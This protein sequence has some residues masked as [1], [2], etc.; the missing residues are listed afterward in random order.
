MPLESAI[1]YAD[2]I[3]T[4]ICDGFV[5]GPFDDPPFP[6]FRANPLFVIKQ[7]NKLR[8]ILDLSS[9]E[10]QSFNDA[11][12][13]SQV[14]D[15]SMALPRDIADLLLEFGNEAFLSKLDHKSAFRLVPVCSSL[16]KLQGFHFIGKYFFE[17]EL[18]LS[19]KSCPAIYN[20]LHEVFLLVARLHS[21]VDK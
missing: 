7:D 4:M 18:I 20:C 21:Q 6:E 13:S 5:V 9:P 1:N 2:Q 8:L 17:T 3:A 11:I 10:G 15:I 12:N 19:N 14:P 16:I